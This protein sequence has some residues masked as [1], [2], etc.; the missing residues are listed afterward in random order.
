MGIEDN[1][2]YDRKR[3]HLASNADL[4]ERIH[5]LSK[6]HN[7]I[8]MAP[9]KLRE[10]LNLYPGNGKYGLDPA[11]QSISQEKAYI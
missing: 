1:I 11:K 8:L 10:L 4:L 7:R 2:W 3:T 5:S 9:S 6:E